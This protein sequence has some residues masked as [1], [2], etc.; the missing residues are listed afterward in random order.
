MIANLLTQRPDMRARRTASKTWSVRLAVAKEAPRGQM[1]A[2]GLNR[3]RPDRAQR[4]RSRR[5]WW[6]RHGAFARGVLTGVVLS[7][8]ACWLLRS[9]GWS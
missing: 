3:R 4:E 7:G 1:H 8:L 2:V 6:D 9:L 5:L